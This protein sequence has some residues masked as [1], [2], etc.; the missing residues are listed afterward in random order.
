MITSQPHALE[1]LC[2]LTY[3]LIMLLFLT[4]LPEKCQTLQIRSED[5]Q[6]IKIKEKI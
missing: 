3:N 4:H 1:C 6:S 2:I 5:L